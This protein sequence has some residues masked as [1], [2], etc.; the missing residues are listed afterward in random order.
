ML[1]K[2]QELKE[3][4]AREK[5]SPPSPSPSPPHHHHHLTWTEHLRREAA[6]EA[7]SDARWKADHSPTNASD[8][9]PAVCCF[10][11][12]PFP[13][14]FARH[15]FPHDHSSTNAR[16]KEIWHPSICKTKQEAQHTSLPARR[17]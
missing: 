3:A 10:T 7:E 13:C 8:G 15:T 11:S 4:E 9:A 6:I 14:A 12:A 16:T 17:G 1:K 2:F 5:S